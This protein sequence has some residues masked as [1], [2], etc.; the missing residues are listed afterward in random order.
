MIQG[1]CTYVYMY[2]HACWR[3]CCER[4]AVPFLFFLLTGSKFGILPFTATS[5]SVV[6][7]VCVLGRQTHLTSITVTCFVTVYLNHCSTTNSI[8]PSYKQKQPDM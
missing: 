1:V 6:V 3:L 5:V 8:K 2:K 4:L 7:C